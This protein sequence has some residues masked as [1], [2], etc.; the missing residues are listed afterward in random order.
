VARPEPIDA[1]VADVGRRLRGPRRLR[2][3]MLVEIRDALEDAAQDLDPDGAAADAGARAVADFGSPA[4]IAGGLQ[5]VLSFAQA[6]R[7][8]CGL[9]AVIGVRHALTLISSRTWDRWWRGAHPS[10]AYTLASRTV[11]GFV[12]AGLLLGVATLVV[13]G[14]ALRRLAPSPT[15]VRA[16]AV[17]APIC[18]AATVGGGLL[19]VAMA[20]AGALG[21][22]LARTGWWLLPFG[23]V[24]RSSWR[25]W[26]AAGA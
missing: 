8:A 3:G 14:P 18:L 13:F 25:C 21:A 6:R 20:P 22:V 17:A 24:L 11:D 4:E 5:E 10:A 26:R 23:L 1:Y 7:T 12:L 9:L 16:V 15:L 2:A 19:L